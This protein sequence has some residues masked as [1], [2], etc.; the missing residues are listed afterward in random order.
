M[1]QVVTRTRK[2]F[3][4]EQVLREVV[5][6]MITLTSEE[7]DFYN[8]VTDAVREYCLLYGQHEGFILS[9]PQRQMAAGSNKRSLREWQK[10]AEINEE[11]V[12]EDYGLENGLNEIQKGPIVAELISKVKKFGD[13]EVLWKSDS[14]YL[15]L[16]KMIQTYLKQNPSEKI[17]LFSYFRAT[18][19][20]LHERLTENGISS[21]ILMGGIDQSKEGVFEKFSEHGGPNILLSS[22]VGSEGI[23]LQFSRIIINYDLPWNP[24]KVEQRIGRN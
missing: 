5:A 23:D 18:L 8:A 6:E 2:I 11:R 10:R 13:L 9:T 19:S 21:I 16:K 22:E 1:G 14:K 12:Y 4:T 20:Y 3:A 17:V 15:R 24:M 7:E